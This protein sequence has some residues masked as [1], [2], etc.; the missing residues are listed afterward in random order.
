MPSNILS[1]HFLFESPKPDHSPESSPLDKVGGKG[2]QGK[3]W[4]RETGGLGGECLREAIAQSR[5]HLRWVLQCSHIPKYSKAAR[6]IWV[7]DGR[8]S[9]VR[10]RKLDLKLQ[11]G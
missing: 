6:A 5:Y 11:G 2:D 9:G 4:Q 8:A 3:V 1:F 10:L 7:M